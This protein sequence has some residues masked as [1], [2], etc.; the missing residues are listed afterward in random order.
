MVTNRSDALSRASWAAL[1]LALLL[2]SPLAAHKARAESFC[3]PGPQDR[4]ET[5][6]QGALTLAEREVAGGFQGQW[7]GARLVGHNPL[8][9]QTGLPRGSF[10]DV[11]LFGHCAYASMRDPSDLTLG[12]TGLAVLDVRVPSNPIWL[13]TLRTPAMQRA[14][15]ALEIQKS[16][17]IGAFKDF[18]PGTGNP[19][20]IYDLSGGCLDA[21]QPRMLATTSTASGNHDGW[22]TPDT[23]T[24][25]GV[26][27]GA[28]TGQ[29]S[30]IRVNPT[31]IDLHVLDLSDKAHPKPLFNWNRNQLPPEIRDRLVPT[32]NFHDISTNEDG[33][34]LYV[35][36]YGGNNALGG[37]DANGAGRCANGL[38]ILDSTQVAKRSPDPVRGYT[39]GYISFLSWCDPKN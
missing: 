25:Y 26:P 23:N 30:D 28:R 15:S 11:Q 31:K 24:Y 35:A 27:F 29:S 16:I 34:R 9:A 3:V 10:G 13:K 5:A 22:L 18:G 6:M 37:F 38:L 39:L 2:L 1:A 17:L 33:T 7:C 12:T 8:L 21:D 19:F 36:L 14:Y 4:P 32:R 20:D